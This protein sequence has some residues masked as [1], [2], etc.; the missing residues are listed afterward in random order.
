[1][2]GKYFMAVPPVHNKAKYPA[3]SNRVDN[4]FISNFIKSS[5]EEILLG[6]KKQ[7]IPCWGQLASDKPPAQLSL[8]QA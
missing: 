2:C 7:K 4:I 5:K 3:V 1:M 6:D 8:P